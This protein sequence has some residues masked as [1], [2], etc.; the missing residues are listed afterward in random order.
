M[1]L[2]VRLYLIEEDGTIKRIPRRVADKMTSG[3]DAIPA[4]AGT[5][6][7]LRPA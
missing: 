6:A 2:T 3:D 4:Y 5:P 1:A 7:E